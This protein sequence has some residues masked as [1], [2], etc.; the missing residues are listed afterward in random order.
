MATNRIE[1]I[2]QMLTAALQPEQLEV[3]DDSA[4]HIGHA[5]AEGGMGHYTVQIISSQFEG[6]S[7]VQRHQM[8][9]AALG[10]ML[11]TD[12]HALRILAKTP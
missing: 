2:K 7:M 9:Y 10:D 6:K 11:K 5:G 3:L 8:V 1:T 4:D 12:I